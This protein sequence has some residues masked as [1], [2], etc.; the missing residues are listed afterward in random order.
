MS[1]KGG[2]DSGLTS[3]STSKAANQKGY[4]HVQIRNPNTEIPGPDLERGLGVN[5]Q[6]LRNPI[7]PALHSGN[8]A[9]P[10]PVP[11]SGRGGQAETISKSQYPPAMQY[12]WHEADIG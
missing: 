1:R 12:Q 10:D 8:V 5:T 6:Q 2:F 9:P 3:K 4:C 11:V 7:M